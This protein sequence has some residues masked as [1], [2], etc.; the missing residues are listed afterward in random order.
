MTGTATFDD[1]LHAAR[2]PRIA[3]HEPLTYAEH[4]EHSFF[5]DHYRA[6]FLS[7]QVAEARLER[8][9]Q[10][11]R[12]EL[13]ARADRP[14]PLRY[15]GDA[16]A[17][18]AT[19]ERRAV[20]LDPGFGGYSIPPLWLVELL[21]TAPR[22]ERIIGDLV[23]SFDLPMGVA[24]V[25]V[26]RLTAGTATGPT[27]PATPPDNTD[28]V[29]AAT[30]SRCVL[31]A[32]NADVPLQMLEQS[33]VGAGHL[34]RLLMRDLAAD[35]DRQLEAMLTAGSGGSGA[36]AQLQG[37][38]T[39]SGITTVTFSS[40][41]PTATGLY[42]LLGQ[43]FGAVSNAR[44]LRPE[45][46]ILR[47]GRFAWLATS[48]DAQSRPLEVPL[49]ATSYVRNPVLPTP[50]GGLVGLPIFTSESISST[51]GAGA[52][53]DTILAVRPS[54]L[55]LWESQPALSIFTE[56]LSGNLEA[57]IQFRQ[58][59]AFIP[60]RYPAGIAQITGTGLV[61]QTNE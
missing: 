25:N 21:A 27:P 53:Q 43:A 17:P 22:P 6:R 36:Q 60:G 31:V 44:K 46:W 54:D 55:L 23:P 30:T 16:P 29:D 33:A 26:P 37:V 2:N 59:A 11:A 18:D 14:E 58:Y 48:E 24:T 15:R 12:V 47:G 57:R 7:D 1:R 41:S 51:L 3:V 4:G 45:C 52:N 61:V 19:F 34:D 49:A 5:A 56:A 8:H 10:E 28:F 13:R 42:P 9:E 35:Y 20:T 38:S 39:L 50:V 32:G 40:G